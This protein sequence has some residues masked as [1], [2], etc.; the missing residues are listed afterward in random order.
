MNLSFEGIG[1]ILGYENEKA[2]IEVNA[3][4]SIHKFKKINVNDRII[5]WSRR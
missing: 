5:C 4:W 1:A 2:K 3:R